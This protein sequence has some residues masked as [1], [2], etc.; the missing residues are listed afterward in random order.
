MGRIASLQDEPRPEGDDWALW[1]DMLIMA[2]GFTEG[3]APY[4]ITVDEFRK[5]NEHDAPRAGWARAKDVLRRALRSAPEEDVEDDI[6]WIRFLG[7]GLSYRAYAAEC[8]GKELVVRLPRHDAG[9]EL[10][11]LAWREVRVLQHLRALQPPLPA[12]LPHVVAAVPIEEGVALVQERVA[13]V[14]L[15]VA[16]RNP[17]VRPWEVVAEAAALCHGVEPGPLEGAIP[18]HPTRRA[19]AIAELAVLDELDFPEAAGARA[20]AHAHLPPETPARLLH[21]DLLGQNLLVA[22]EDEEPLGLIDW[23]HALI[24]DPAYDLAIVTRGARRP[25]KLEGGLAKLLD[26]YERRSGM[27]IAVAEVRLHELCLLARFCLD[28]FRA[29]GRASPRAEDARRRFAALLRRAAA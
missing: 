6:G 16:A 7:E 15:D 9:E 20:W 13:G 2:V 14:P 11:A 1:G 3:G 18:F 21:G 29:F 10:K 5:Y 12:R 27:R 17:G 22:L 24:G 19:H 4:G 28:D 8:R 23:S 26:A 25:F